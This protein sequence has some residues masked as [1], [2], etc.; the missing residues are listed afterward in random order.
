[1]PLCGEISLEDISV[2]VYVGSS[3]GLET[4]DRPS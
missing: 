2:E 3:H 1:M 4:E